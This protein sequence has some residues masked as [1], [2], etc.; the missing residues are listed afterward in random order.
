M[1]V[2]FRFDARAW[3]V[4]EAR[5]AIQTL[6]TL[7]DHPSR[8]TVAGEPTGA[9][10]IPVWVGEPAGAGE[11]A[12]AVIPV[13]PWEEW[14]PQ[15][16]RLATFEGVSLPCPSGRMTH[17]ENPAHLPSVWLRAIAFLLTREEEW[18]SERRDQ[19]QCFA[20]NY[21]RSHDL[22]ILEQPLIDAY[23]KQLRRR[24][25]TW[26][27]RFGRQ[28]EPVPR[29]KDGS[30]FAVVLSHDVDDIRFYSWRDALRLLGRARS[31]VSYAVRRSLVQLAR[32]LARGRAPGDPYWSFAKWIAEEQSH[33]FRSSYYV[34]PSRPSRPH[35]YD[36]TYRLADPIEFEGSSMTFSSVLR[37]LLERGFEIG[38]HASYRSYESG[39][40]LRRQKLQ[41]ESALGAPV[42]GIRQHFLRFEAR[43]TWAAQEEA[44]FVYDTTLGYNEAI[45]FRAGI[46]APFRPWDASR[47]E[48]RR[49]LELPLMVMD[50]ALFRTLKLD[51]PTAA[52]RTIEHLRTVEDV[53]GLAV[54]LWHPNGADQEHFP[55][56]WDAYREILLYLSRRP[57][58]V[59]PAGE[60]ARWWIEREE[61]L[62]GS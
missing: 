35:E 27:V 54:L 6:A 59:A 47:R 24:I 30:R 26:C 29:W 21:S 8:L 1:R 51:G 22:G 44:G 55:G 62:L 39:E 42:Q 53:G 49:I 48:R 20:G 23:A 36:A 45:G 9:E 15:S 19:W 4:L 60:L 52:R 10:E 25:D 11:N 41:V 58:W 38:L 50:G 37:I 34:F 33:G 12:A 3:E 16:L 56:W 28:P 13:L 31:P 40:E 14:D 5:Y 57:A 32:T 61:R 46:A 43:R 2:C 18:R 17:P 7:L